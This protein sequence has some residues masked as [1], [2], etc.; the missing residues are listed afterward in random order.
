MLTVT[1]DRITKLVFYHPYLIIIKSVPLFFFF[2]VFNH[3]FFHSF[4]HSFLHAFIYSIHHPSIEPYLKPSN[5]LTGRQVK[6]IPGQ[7]CYSGASLSRFL[8]G[9]GGSVHI[10]DREEIDGVSSRNYCIL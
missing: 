7:T 10:A 1:F 4:V 9:L 2:I 6:G 5:G 3:A 8:K